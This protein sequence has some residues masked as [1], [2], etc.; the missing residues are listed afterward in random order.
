MLHIAVGVFFLDCLLFAVFHQWL[1][2]GTLLY[3]IFSVLLAQELKRSAA[4]YISL[5]M[6]M[7]RDFV[8]YG[9][10]GLS[11]LFALGIIFMIKNLKNVL[12]NA[13]I[14][15]LTMSIILF[16]ILEN[17]V[18]YRFLFNNPQTFWMTNVK[19]FINVI[20]GY[21]VLLGILGNRSLK[22]SVGRGRK[23]WTPNRK[24]ALQG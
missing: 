21:I 16:F 14:L 12:R 18:V 24:D 8:A 17:I 13:Q 6:L 20:S 4:I 5:S 19:I 15:L 3:F 10:F 11:V 22:T 9:R 2:Y 1:V 23:V 7:L